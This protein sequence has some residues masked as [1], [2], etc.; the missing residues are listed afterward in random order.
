M[1]RIVIS[2]TLL[3]AALAAC[4]KSS[5]DV[6]SRNAAAIVAVRGGGQRDTV[7]G[8]L[9]DS[10]VVKVTDQAG[11]PLQGATVDWL[12]TEGGGSFNSSSTKTDAN[13]LTAVTWSVGVIAGPQI[14]TAT[15]GNVAPATFTATATPG[16]PASLSFSGDGQLAP[17]GTPVA[18]PLLVLIKD[19]WGNV[20]PGVSVAWA[21]N[22]GG[23]ALSASSV[24][25][26]SAGRAQVTW[27]LGSAGPQSATASRDSLSHIFSATA[28]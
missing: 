2:L 19:K 15:V 8:T 13:G 27:T 6:I 5:S 18:A 22:T 17:V 3:A 20:V 16:A 7:V 21:V 14:A 26:D 1:R 24:L 11:A 10:L 4:G 9:P 28:F 12:A 23:G 25:T